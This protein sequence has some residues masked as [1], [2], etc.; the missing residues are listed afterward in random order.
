MVNL[1]G[2]AALTPH[3][4]PVVATMGRR[5]DGEWAR[6]AS[7]ALGK[8]ENVTLSKIIII[9]PLSFPSFYLL[10]A[11]LSTHHYNEQVS[12]IFN[13]FKIV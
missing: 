8:R 10:F 7:A 3:A 12:L 5:G 11:L 4:T 6:E 9:T 13:R 1:F 2:D